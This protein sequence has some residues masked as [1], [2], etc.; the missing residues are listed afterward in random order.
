MHFLRLLLLC[1]L[2]GSLISCA[3]HSTETKTDSSQVIVK[4]SFTNL[5]SENLEAFRANARAGK[6]DYARVYTNLLQRADTALADQLY[7]VMQKKLVAASG[8][9]HDYL[10]LAPYWWPDPEKADGLPWIRRD[11][12]VNPETKN[13]SVDDKSKDRAFAN[14]G[15]LARAAYFS[16]ERKYADRTV[17]QL[18]VWFL[19]PE[20]KMNPNL[21]YAQGIPGLNDGRC[22]GIIEFTGVQDIITSLELLAAENLL[23]D[24]IESGMQQWL[25]AMTNWLLTSPLGIEEGSRTNNH[26]NWYDVQ[27]VTLLRYLGRDD[28]ARQMLEAAKTQR[29]AAQ[30]APDGSQP[31]ELARTRS[32][33]YSRMNLEAMTRLAWHGRQLG[34]DLWGFT[35]PDGRS[36]RKAYDYLYPY[37]FEDK[38]WP[39][40]QL[41]DIDKVRK[42]VREMFYKT[43]G[44]FQVAEFC[45]LR[46]KAALAEPDLELLLH[47]CPN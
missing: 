31:E 30:I 46:E 3:E 23:P 42:Q 26:A 7:T 8:D 15:L 17:E 12:E 33:G 6:S 1:C 5:D 32:L 40:E 37:T 28:E 13:D 27:V 35:T 36:L 39:Y 2:A 44:R 24:T 4:Q 22:F 45:A 14:I 16:G 38:A 20:T 19:D 25:T 21:N 18:R 41:G 47:T 34:V 9:K 29:I 11:G 10:S 43:G